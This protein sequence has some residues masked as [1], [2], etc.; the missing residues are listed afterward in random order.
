MPFRKLVLHESDKIAELEEEVCQEYFELD[1]KDTFSSS[2][3]DLAAITASKELK[4]EKVER[5]THQGDEVGA[6]AVGELTRSFNKVKLLIIPVVCIL[7]YLHLN[8]I[9]LILLLLGNN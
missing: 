7:Q 5:D 6:G 4:V 9:Y 1:F 2:V 3:Q 8:H